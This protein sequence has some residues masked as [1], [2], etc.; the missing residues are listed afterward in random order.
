VRPQVETLGY[1]HASLRDE[2]AQILVT[3]DKNVRAPPNSYTGEPQADCQSAKQRVA[4][5]RY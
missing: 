2:D 4:N 5:L 3:S 1:S